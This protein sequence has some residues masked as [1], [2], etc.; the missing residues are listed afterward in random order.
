MGIEK[1]D[2][3]FRKKFFS[4]AKDVKRPSRVNSLFIDCN[5]IFH[6]VKHKVFPLVTTKKG[7]T[8]KDYKK[9]YTTKGLRETFISGIIEE[10]NRIIDDYQPEDNLIIAPDGVANAAKLYQQKTRRFNPKDE[11]YYSFDGNSL[12]PGT[13]IMISIDKAIKKWLEKKASKGKLPPNTIY[14][15]HMDP[16]EGEHKIFHY[17]RKNMIITEIS[18]SEDELSSSSDEEDWDELL[19]SSEKEEPAHI[20]YGADGDL[21]ILSLLSP[22]KNIYLYRDNNKLLYDIEKFKNG[23]W[24]S[25]SF[26]GCDKKRLFQD[27]AL[28]VIF[29]GNDFLPKFPNLPGTTDTLFDI[30]FK[31]YRSMKMHLTDDKNNIDWDRFLIFLKKLDNW[32]INKTDDTYFY[33][34]DKLNFPVKEIRD[35]TIIKDYKGRIVPWKEGD[36]DQSRHTREF[37]KRDFEKD[38]YEKQFKPRN[39]KLFKQAKKDSYY[40]MKDV[41]NMCVCFLRTLQWNQW[42]YTKGYKKVSNHFFYPYRITPLVHNLSFYL[43]SIVNQNQKYILNEKINYDPDQFKI[44]P[45]H[46]LMSVLPPSSCDLIPKEFRVLYNNTKSINPS[47]YIILPPENTD[48]DYHHV[49]LIPPINLDLIEMLIRE[50]EI[51]ISKKYRLEKYIKYVENEKI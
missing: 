36:Y 49:P 42:Y 16:G 32:K 29:V 27:F 39:N 17:I 4:F 5:G 22:L 14:S 24:R 1:F 46:Q 35:H 34:W 19:S 8:V 21:F 31:I 12:T 10:L 20:V 50:S 15:S 23:V 47:E 9:K 11:N 18:S 48:A 40:S 3:I 13:E 37:K 33:A 51:P 41:F 2:N 26:D 38:W 43:N 28:L 7:E 30:M 25:I 45:I 6:G 44:T